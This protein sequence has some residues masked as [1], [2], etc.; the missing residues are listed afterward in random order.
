MTQTM[1][2]SSRRLSLPVDAFERTL[3]TATRVRK[4]SRVR[5]SGVRTEVRESGV[6][7]EVRESGVRSDVLESGV[8]TE[9]RGSGVRSQVRG[10]GVRSEE[11]S[12]RSRKRKVWEIPP[13][14][15]VNPQ[16]PE[17]IY[18]LQPPGRVYDDAVNGD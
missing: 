5:D 8:R 11:P 6:R 15:G 18:Y 16:S 14:S 3:E 10:S 4:I 9:F 12:C 7:S 17:V 13:D 1:Y 2:G